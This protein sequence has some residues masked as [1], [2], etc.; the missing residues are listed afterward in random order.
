VAGAAFAGY[1]FESR[2]V[3]RATV[4]VFGERKIFDVLEVLEF[5]STRKRMS[6]VV[7]RPSGE[8]LLYSKGA[9]MMIYQRLKDDPSQETL[10]KVTRDHMEQYADD[11]LRTLALAVKPL[12]EKWFQKWK[13][14]FD[15]A[16]GNVGE[17]DKRKDGKPNAIDD[18]MEEIEENLELIGA[19]AIEDKLQDGVP[20]CLEHLTAAGIKVWMLTGD[21][22]ETAINIAYACSL[23]DN[24]IQQVIINC[25]SCPTE[26]AIRARLNAVTREY[27]E[28]NKG[29]D[30]KPEIALV[31][32]GEALE[33]ALKP[34]TA[35]HLLEFAKLCRA[36]ICNRVSP[37]QKAEMVSLV[38][39]N[40][41][42]VRTLAIGDGANDVAMIQAA[43]VGVGISGQEGMQAV[44]SSDYAIAQFRFLERLLLVHGRWNYIRI[45]KLVL[46]MFYKN[47]TLV[48]SQYWYGYLSG[49]S[50]S[51]MYWELGVQVYNVLFTGLPIVVLGV[52][53]KDLPDHF[54]LDFPRLYRK[55]PE[56]AYF[57]YFTFL[58]WIG[59][60]VF[61]SIVVFVVMA[62]G[63]NASESAP[64][65]ESRVE[66]GMLA[67]TLVVMIVNLKICLITNT[68]TVVSISC[69]L[70]SILSWYGFAAMGTEV[71][72]FGRMKV[73]YDEYG[74]FAPTASSAGYFLLVIIGC[75]IALGRHFAW[76]QYQRLFYPEGYQ[77]LQ[78]SL[79][80]RVGRLTIDHIEEQT[81]S[82]SLEDL[83]GTELV[84][85][86]AT[87]YDIY[88]TAP[89]H[90]SE[91][92]FTGRADNHQNEVEVF[93]AAITV[94]GSIVSDSTSLVG[95]GSFSAS[96]YSDSFHND[97]SMWEKPGGKP[98][99]KQSVSRRNT[100]YAFSCD[101][102]T[103]L[104][105]S[106][107]AS[108]SLPRSDAV[109]AALRNS[110]Q[111]H[112]I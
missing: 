23:L 75:M 1:Q 22:E 53:D 54:S 42:S 95:A 79:N 17:I 41:K 47:I 20:K 94:P 48:L 55:G 43:H 88:K 87:D 96:V 2:S 66:F 61:E 25:T 34:T 52:M 56:R 30:I 29:I 57:N 82:M 100:G 68:W 67:F 24:S 59:A 37:A 32:D 63:F 8:L 103:T 7:R 108:N 69:S 45:S 92:D 84:E 106:Y 21:K 19:T 83:H 35:L 11:G 111:R 112:D 93:E 71:S 102:E 77:I 16:Q 10:K 85:S 89:H 109:P 98:P 36:V 73:G 50:G 39:D 28:K 31:I 105:E 46:Y 104:A 49:A 58:R 80:K 62:L 40:I 26:D 51:K 86:R 110:L 14:R 72:F 97:P 6:V 4:S 13:I 33:F 81:L 27:K 38:R 91:G 12:D 76:N 64:G 60:A 65:S 5:N 90:S 74:S 18:L 78:E 9:D 3:G 101:E 107:I 15:E 44:N 99:F 70:G